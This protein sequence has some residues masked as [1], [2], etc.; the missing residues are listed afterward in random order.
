MEFP[1]HF[2]R[3]PRTAEIELVLNPHVGRVDLDP[4]GVGLGCVI[5]QLQLLVRSFLLALGRLLDAP[6]LSILELPQIGDHTLPWP[7]I[8]S[9]RFDQRPVGVS[10]AIRFPVTWP[11]EHARILGSNRGRSSRKVFTTTRFNIHH[12][13]TCLLGVNPGKLH[14]PS[15]P[16]SPENIS[17][18]IDFQAV[19]AKLG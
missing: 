8:G 16:V 12:A 17:G 9:I 5:E 15:D 11:D 6:P 7:A 13:K 3:E 18:K 4:L 19:L 10:L 14:T 2:Q 1:Y